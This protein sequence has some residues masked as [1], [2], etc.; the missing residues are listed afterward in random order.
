MLSR[1]FKLAA[2]TLIIS[3]SVFIPQSQSQTAALELT[4]LAQS[5]AFEQFQNRDVSERSKLLFLVDRL[6][7]S[8]IKEIVYEGR[9]YH[10]L[11]VTGIARLYLSRHYKQEHAESWLSKFC[12]R[13]IKSGAPV[14]VKLQNGE[15]VNAKE[16]L[17]DEL[18][19]LETVDG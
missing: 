15:C 11:F 16:I 14:L 4:P 19:K 18:Q 9:A 1:N 2:L 6:N 3:S 8:N 7:E 5:R 12:F 17:L 13:T 10:P